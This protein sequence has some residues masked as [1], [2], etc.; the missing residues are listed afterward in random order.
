M[1]MHIRMML[2]L[3]IVLDW[4]NLWGRNAFRVTDDQVKTAFR[5]LNALQ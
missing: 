4:K 5:D 2:I 1:N 3:V